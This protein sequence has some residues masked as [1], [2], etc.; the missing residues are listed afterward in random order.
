MSPFEPG[1]VTLRGSGIDS[2][3]SQRPRSLLEDA[4]WEDEGNLGMSADFDH[5]GNDW[6]RKV[7]ESPVVAPV[8]MRPVIYMYC[9]SHRWYRI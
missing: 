3:H 8:M 7:Y 5:I 9:K 2:G 4:P 6:L 1:T